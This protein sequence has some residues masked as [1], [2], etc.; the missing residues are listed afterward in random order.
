M[1]RINRTTEQSQS[2]QLFRI[3]LE[4]PN[5]REL[6]DDM[7]FT[8]L[9]K[10]FLR[11]LHIYEANK[12]N[13]WMRDDALFADDS[14]ITNAI[15]V[16]ALET[17]GILEA[18]E[19]REIHN[20]VSD[21]RFQL[22]I[23][24]LMY[25]QESEASEEEYA[26]F[27]RY[28]DLP[29]ASLRHLLHT[30]SKNLAEV[31]CTSYWNDGHGAHDV[32]GV[33]AAKKSNAF[34]LL[35]YKKSLEKQWAFER[36]IKRITSNEH[37]KQ[38]IPPPEQWVQWLSTNEYRQGQQAT[39]E[40]ANAGANWQHEINQKFDKPISDYTEE[41]VEALL[42]IEIQRGRMTITYSED[43]KQRIKEFFERNRAAM[44]ASYK[45]MSHIIGSVYHDLARRAASAISELLMILHETFTNDDQPN[46]EFRA[47]PLEVFLYN[48]FFSDAEHASDISELF[49]MDIDVVVQYFKLLI[50][51]L[52]QL[53]DKKISNTSK[54]VISDT[55]VGAERVRL[56]AFYKEL[57]TTR[58]R[59]LYFCLLGF[60]DG[61]STLEEGAEKLAKI[62]VRHYA[63]VKALRQHRPGM[64][65][66][67]ESY[68]KQSDKER[69]L[70]NRFLAISTLDQKVLNGDVQ[71]QLFIF[72]DRINECRRSYEAAILNAPH[73]RHIQEM[74]ARA[75]EWQLTEN[76]S[77]NEQL[78]REVLLSLIKDHDDFVAAQWEKYKKNEA[79][80]LQMYTLDDLCLRL[81]E[82]EIS[83]I[84]TRHETR[85][86][87][88]SNSPYRLQLEQDAN[89]RLIRETHEAKQRFRFDEWSGSQRSMASLL[90]LSSDA[91]VD[92]DTTETI[93]TF[94]IQYIDVQN[95]LTSIRVGQRDAS[96]LRLHSDYHQAELA[97][98]DQYKLFSKKSRYMRIAA[99]YSPDIRR[100]LN[101]ERGQR[102]MRR[103]GFLRKL[104]LG[105]SASLGLCALGVASVA[106]GGLIALTAG[107]VIGLYAGGGVFTA[108]SVIAAY[109]TRSRR[110]NRLERRHSPMFATYI[111]DTDS[112]EGCFLGEPQ[113]I[114]ALLDLEL[115]ERQADDQRRIDALLSPARDRLQELRTPRRPDKDDDA[116]SFVGVLSPQQ[117]IAP[118]PG[119]DMSDWDETHPNMRKLHVERTPASS[120]RMQRS[121]S[122]IDLVACMR[123]GLFPP[124]EGEGDEAA[125]AVAFGYNRHD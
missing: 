80:L 96:D 8:T 85:L 106:S 16:Y 75:L 114:D 115:A 77:K 117:Q 87:V 66:E 70:R 121:V 20:W 1:S 102:R 116:R 104:G 5:P 57:P 15:V 26:F 32:L 18:R 11:I 98:R 6:N 56:G 52:Y 10:F 93:T 43:E 107:V 105:V 9:E 120:N 3:L 108:G 36:L 13:G 90:T 40:F 41:D 2:E 81:Y 110:N 62:F 54:E 49:S 31:L 42:N 29:I 60:V 111:T 46:P 86:E 38:C 88:A 35:D 24:H 63:E 25:W 30:L 123:R 34:R 12:Y 71:E 65:A 78:K 119:G 118:I 23:A 4:N 113:D 84:K 82:K 45:T 22:M 76:L 44:T 92:C 67:P 61:C 17:P 79:E 103:R 28:V 50:K 39:G 72:E 112:D 58:V 64:D 94:M 95:K 89:D 97:H 101:R 51:T 91:H 74:N 47:R 33:L 69:K 100:E 122:Q 19:L 68:G 124:E 109:L 37:R 7:F 99:N 59:D 14:L 27:K 55:F 53:K 21:E 73:H 83:L 48:Y 125:V